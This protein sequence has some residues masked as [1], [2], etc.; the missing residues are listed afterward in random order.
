MIEAGKHRARALHAELGLT[1]NGFEQ[2]G[3]E[4]ELLD[5]PG[6][7]I[8]YYGVF[9]GGAQEWTIKAMRTAGFRGT[10]IT[11][12]SSLTGETPEV[13]L[14]VEHEKYERRVRAK[15]KFV[16]TMGGVSMKDPLSGDRAK[17]FAAKMKGVFLSDER[18]NGGGTKTQA[19]KRQAQRTVP[20]GV[21]PK[22]ASTQGAELAD[23]DIPF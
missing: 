11:D 15:V 23:D 9:T 8:S 14:V 10:D 17:A 12:M 13:L 20:K 18:S 5:L 22:A 6:Q 21:A 4:F 16:N 3:I 2:I 1:K 19:P 7:R